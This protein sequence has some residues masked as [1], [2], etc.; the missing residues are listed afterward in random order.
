LWNA[1]ICISAIYSFLQSSIH[2]FLSSPAVVIFI[3]L[4]HTFSCLTHKFTLFCIPESAT[5]S[6]SSFT[7][8]QSNPILHDSFGCTI[9]VIVIVDLKQ[10]IH[11]TGKG[12]HGRNSRSHINGIKILNLYI[13]AITNTH[14]ITIA[15]TPTSANP[16]PRTTPRRIH[17]PHRSQ[18]HTPRNILPRPPSRQTLRARIG[19][20]ESRPPTRLLHRHLR[21]LRKIPR[22]RRPKPRIGK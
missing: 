20:H 2:P 7:A 10:L 1:C 17:N 9:I 16:F 6:R 11:K 8:I 15:A 14:P 21:E 13:Y 18:Q 19:T 22:G 4:N 12:S 3:P 5:S